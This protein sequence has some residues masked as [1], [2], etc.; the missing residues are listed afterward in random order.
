M[1]DGCSRYYSEQRE[2]TSVLSRAHSQ[3]SELE[4]SVNNTLLAVIRH[5]LSNA[6]ALEFV[7]SILARPSLEV[8]E[9]QTFKPFRI[10]F[11][12]VVMVVH[13]CLLCLFLEF[14]L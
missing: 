4:A 9:L 2:L 7:L 8:L 3:C 5:P 14:A 11:A 6:S 10:S 1:F 13:S 12:V